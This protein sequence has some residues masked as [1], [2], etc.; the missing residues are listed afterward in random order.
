MKL[1]DLIDQEGDTKEVMSKLL[2]KRADKGNAPSERRERKQ[3]RGK[4]TN[5]NAPAIAQAP[6]PSDD[7][8][9]Q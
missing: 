5:T 3:D 4:P 6:T 1:R 9:M 7:G 8:V 2:R